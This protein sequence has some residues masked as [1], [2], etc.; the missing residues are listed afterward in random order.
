MILRK[1]DEIVGTEH[2]VHTKTWN[3][4][5]LLLKKDGVRFSLNDTLIKAGTETAIWYKNHVEAVYCIEGEGEIEIV[6][7]GTVH[8]IR[9]GTLYVLD[10]HEK[11]VLR[12][13]STMR[14]VCVFDPPLTG[15]EVHDAEGAYPLIEE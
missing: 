10:G 5:R 8:P 14:M 15:R 12:A 3:S 4:R 11:H 9:P 6:E 2:D 13:T 1:L 7:S